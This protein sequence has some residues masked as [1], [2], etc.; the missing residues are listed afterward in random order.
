MKITRFIHLA[1]AL[2]L[3]GCATGRGINKGQLNMYSYESEKE[4]GRQYS[5]MV[6]SQFPP[7]YDA[8]VNAYVDT[9]GQKMVN[10]ATDPLFN[11]QFRVFKTAMV[12]AFTVGAG[13]I[14]F[15]IGIMDAAPNEA[16]LASVVGHEIGHVLSR[17]VTER[18]T[19]ANLL[20]LAASMAGA[21]AGDAI[22]LFGNLG[23]L[24]FGKAD[25]LEADQLGLGLLHRSNYN[26][27]GGVQMFKVL[28]KLA[29]NQATVPLLSDL[30]ST[31]PKPQDR[32]DRLNKLI[33]RYKK[34]TA[35]ITTDTKKFRSIKSRIQ[36]YLKEFKRIGE[37]TPRG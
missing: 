19:Q 9:I 20:G 35:S 13:Y 37:R 36:K 22:N 33:P 17:H 25:E 10:V 31:H 23:L 4:I 21:G 30:L 24:Q 16:A 29:E 32:I 15:T 18:L 1:L 34:R 11:Y 2:I 28:K 3:C 7:L 8:E 14:F 6:S 5:A 26:M 27:T 12:N